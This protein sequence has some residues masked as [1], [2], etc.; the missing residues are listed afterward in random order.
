MK[1]LAFICFFAFQGLI[2]HVIF[3]VPPY[4]L[5]FSLAC[6]FVIA[7]RAKTVQ[8]NAWTVFLLLFSFLY[9][10]LSQ[11]VLEV[12]VKRLIPI[13]LQFVILIFM[14]SITQI[15]KNL[16]QK[17]LIFLL[18]SSVV[19]FFLDTVWRLTHPELERIGVN[20]DQGEFAYLYAFK[21]N[22]LIYSDTNVMA[23][24]LLCLM[25]FFVVAKQLGK[26]K[27]RNIWLWTLGVLII[28]TFSRAGII[29]MLLGLLLIYFQKMNI[30][31]KVVF[32]I[33]G[34]FGIVWSLGTFDFT[35]FEDGSFRSKLFI[36]DNFLSYLEVQT[37]E[38]FLFGNGLYQSNKATGIYSHNLLIVLYVETG[39]FGFIFYLSYLGVLVNHAGKKFL[40]VLFPVLLAS[41]G[42]ALLS[43]PLLYSS[44]HLLNDKTLKTD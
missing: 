2:T 21:S 19:I 13:L 41:M 35:S 20:I 12:E 40:Y 25:F 32:F 4:L 7:S 6:V 27:V 31:F 1:N 8:L 30:I 10:L 34:I 15:D 18:V 28:F 23:I 33:F 9:F 39:I 42:G 44:A 36:F 14:L 11:V 37:A 3:P 29:S 17:T 38:S 16:Y 26:L 5:F 24:H 43:F 22:S